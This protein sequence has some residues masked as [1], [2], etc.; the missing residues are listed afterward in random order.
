VVLA[1]EEL[2]DISSR[3]FMS[4]IRTSKVLYHNKQLDITADVLAVLDAA[5]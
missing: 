3:E 1:S 2:N 4:F 5:K